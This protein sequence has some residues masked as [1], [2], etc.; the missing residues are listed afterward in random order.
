MSRSHFPTDIRGI[1]ECDSL[2][3]ACFMSKADAKRYRFVQPADYCSESAVIGDCWIVDKDGQIN[4]GTNV[5][6]VPIHRDCIGR[7]I[8]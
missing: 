4:P 2:S 5:S 8:N 7:R 3:D 6:P 1:Y